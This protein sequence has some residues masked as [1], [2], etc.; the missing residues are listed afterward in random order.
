ME[1]VSIDFLSKNSGNCVI[2]KE[3]CWR[4]NYFYLLLQLISKYID[5]FLNKKLL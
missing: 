4:I 2:S 1:C 3:K 5:C